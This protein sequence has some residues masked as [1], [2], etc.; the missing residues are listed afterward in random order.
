[1]T[2]AICELPDQR[3]SRGTSRGMGLY[4][5][6]GRSL[7]RFRAMGPVRCWNPGKDQPIDALVRFGSIDFKDRGRASLSPVLLDGYRRGRLA[8]T[9]TPRAAKCGVGAHPDRKASSA[10][11]LVGRGSHD[12]AR[13][14]VGRGSHDPARG[15]TAGLRLPI[16]RSTLNRT[17]SSCVQLVPHT[18]QSRGLGAHPDHG[19]QSDK[20]GYQAVITARGPCR[21]ARR[22]RYPLLNS[23][24]RENGRSC[25]RCTDN[26]AIASLGRK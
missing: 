3:S 7:R 19:R 25:V 9:L 17:L 6:L 23:I 2:E 4:R 15:S 22:G 12:L 24:E 1:M 10:T 8:R 18:S 26:I 14:L 16:R 5:R 13:V 21:D 20:R 11:V